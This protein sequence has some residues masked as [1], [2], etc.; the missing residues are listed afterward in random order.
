MKSILLAVVAVV[1]M[2]SLSACNTVHGFGK[3]VQK[4]GDKIE[5]AAQK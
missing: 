1:A 2:A 4:L 5:G 3:D